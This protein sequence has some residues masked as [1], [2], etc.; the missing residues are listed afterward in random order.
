MQDLSPAQT[1]RA[2]IQSTPWELT[3]CHVA[4]LLGQVRRLHALDIVHGD[5]HLENVMTRVEEGTGERRFFLID[6]GQALERRQWC[7]GGESVRSAWED[8]EMVIQELLEFPE[9]PGVQQLK[10]LRNIWLFR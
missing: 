4:R 2:W 7:L 8:Y 6:F 5:L 9:C 3:A 10:A 1:V